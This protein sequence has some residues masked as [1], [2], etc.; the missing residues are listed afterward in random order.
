MAVT[1]H[2]HTKLDAVEEIKNIILENVTKH[3]R[4]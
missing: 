4:K 1:H 3:A 2:T